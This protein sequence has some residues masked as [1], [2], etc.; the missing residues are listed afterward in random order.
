VRCTGNVAL[1]L[2]LVA[3]ALAAAGFALAQGP[4]YQ[5]AEIVLE[6]PEPGRATAARVHIDYVNPA[7]PAAKPPA[8]MQV[9]E[10]LPPGSRIDTSAPEIC[11]ASD[12]Q[13][14]LMGQGAC[15]PGSNVGG[16]EV[17]LDAGTGALPFDVTLF[18]NRNELILFFEQ[19]GGGVRTPSRAKVEGDRPDG[20]RFIAQV[21][22][23][24]GGPPDG[25]TAIKR[26]RVRI[27]A[28]TR[29][30]KNYVTTPPTC[31]AG[32]WISRLDF[33]YRDGTEQTVTNRSPCNPADDVA[34][35]RSPPR[36]TIRGVPRR[37]ASRGL[38]LRIRIRD[39]SRL[40]RASVR[41]DGRLLRTT[42]RKRVRLR[43]RSRTIAPGRHRVTV[44][45]RDQRGN[46][47]SRSMR[48]RRCS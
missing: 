44:V 34:L 32:G 26:V 37:C 39:G 41:L 35:D 13:F 33:T 3:L 11:T 1:I 22:P 8:V 31:P 29:G 21:P 4:A 47:A 15:P 2:V 48:F 23:I 10:I 14:D 18:N 17:D 45:A 5:T 9:V 30:G 16:G 25:F 20:P 42:T 27:D 38:R 46:R 6:E 24:P 7:D 43:L 28:I 19:R 12:A 40:R 36:I